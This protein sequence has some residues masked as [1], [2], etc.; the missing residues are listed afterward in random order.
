MAGLYDDVAL[1]ALDTE[2]TEQVLLQLTGYDDDDANDVF[3]LRL[4]SVCALLQLRR[5]VVELRASNE[6]LR[7][8]AQLATSKARL[9][10]PAPSETA[11]LTLHV[12]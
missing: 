6:R 8:E 5:E 9:A 2:E 1:P 10:L 12:V 3:S 7:R 11:Q 4:L